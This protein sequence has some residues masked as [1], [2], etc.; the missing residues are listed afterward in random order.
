MALVIALLSVLVIVEGSTTTQWQ[1]KQVYHHSMN[2]SGNDTLNC[3]NTWFFTRQFDN[4]SSACECGSDLGEVISCD[5]VSGQVEL[6]E[7]YCMTYD[8]D[9][10]SLVVA[11]CYF[12]SSH[13]S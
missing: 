13:I 1:N 8:V 10:I 12:A 7:N 11:M 9:N 2:T 4:G 6:L 3:S 5:E